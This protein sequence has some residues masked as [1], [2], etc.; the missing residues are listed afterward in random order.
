MRTS[1]LSV[2]LLSVGLLWGCGAE[3]ET[4][5]VYADPGQ[6]CPTIAEQAPQLTVLLED[7]AL[8]GISRVMGEIVSDDQLAAAL[9]GTLRLMARLTEEEISNLVAIAGHP[10]LSGATHQL[11]SMLH[12]M[13][14]GP[15]G[16]RSDVLEEIQFL[17]QTC[18]GGRTFD[19]LGGLFDAPEIPQ[20]LNALGA[21]LKLPEIQALLSGEGPDPSVL[22]RAGFNA[23]V[24]NMLLKLTEPGYDFDAD[25]RRPLAE[26]GVLPLDTPPLLTLMDA[27]SGVMSPERGVQRALSD[28]VCCGFYGTPTCSTGGT[29][30]DS[31]PILRNLG[32]DLLLAQSVAPTSPTN[33]DLFEA[34]GVLA[35]D[36]IISAALQPLN[37]VLDQ[38][39]EDA[40]LRA[41][42]VDMMVT[43]LEPEN[44]ALML[45]DLEHMISAGA[46][47]ELFGLFGLFT[48]TCTP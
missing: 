38:M 44:M 22:G 6:T 42:L 35:G 5:P 27:L 12:I 24:G 46:A 7:D 47:D 4:A 20:A 45:P 2:G 32:Y 30:R 21:A 41:A 34:L 36:P 40:D 16:L 3:D 25:V 14:S 11:E 43:I 15:E 28:L 33:T 37:T 13:Q 10:S 1:L 8:P 31:P 9:D 39:A 23:I 29:L 26:L 19:A 18:E 48:G 17:L